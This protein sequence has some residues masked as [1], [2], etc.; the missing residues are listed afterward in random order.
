[1]R[2]QPFCKQCGDIKTICGTPAPEYLHYSQLIWIHL[3]EI[4]TQ[5]LN[6]GAQDLVQEVE[7]SQVNVI[8]NVPHPSLLLHIH[9]KLT[10]N[11]FL[12][13]QKINR[14][15]IYHNINLPSS[16]RPLENLQR[17]TNHLDSNL[18]SSPTKCRSNKRRKYKTS[19]D[20]TS[21]GTK[22]RMTKCRMV[23]NVKRT[24]C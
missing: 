12:V 2:P 16:A 4:N 6:L 24:K 13:T 18:R 19:N 17:L 22:C 1:M 9:D 21:N 11:A 3:V 20:K 8:Y 23:Q 10:R 14:D 15:I 7:L 5:Y